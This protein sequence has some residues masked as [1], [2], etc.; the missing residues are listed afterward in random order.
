MQRGKPREGGRT[1]SGHTAWGGLL[2]RGV[3]HLHASGLPPW[4]PTPRPSGVSWPVLLFLICHTK[5]R[6]A[7]GGPWISL[8]DIFHT[9]T[10]FYRRV[11]RGQDRS[12]L[13]GG[14]TRG[15]PDSK[16]EGPGLPPSPPT[17]QGEARRLPQGTGERAGCPAPRKEELNPRLMVTG[18]V[19]QI[20]GLLPAPKRWPEEP[21]PGPRPVNPGSRR[22]H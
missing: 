4:W 18:A 7:L 22:A 11:N 15:Q 20:Y 3:L 21:H 5:E 6:K 13:R 16:L 19:G 12:P 10:S 17:G 8:T 2:P 14:W 1:C 9:V